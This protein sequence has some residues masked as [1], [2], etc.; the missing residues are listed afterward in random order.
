MEELEFIMGE[1][2]IT[3]K[4][5]ADEM[6]MS[7]G[8]FR[9]MLSKWRKTGVKPK[10]ATALIVGYKFGKEEMEKRIANGRTDK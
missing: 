1:R 2:G 8:S 9:A 7:Y 4:E 10:W 3:G 6:N 5:M